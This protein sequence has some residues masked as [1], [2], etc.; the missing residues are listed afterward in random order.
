MVNARTM[1]TL[2]VRTGGTGTEFRSLAV[3]FNTYGAGDSVNAAPLDGVRVAV[4]ASSLK[5]VVQLQLPKGCAFTKD[6][7][8]AAC[9][10]GNLV[11]GHGALTLGV[12]AAVGAKAGAAGS[13]LF[14]VTATNAV[15]QTYAGEPADE[16]SDFVGVVD[17]PDIVV[18][19]LGTAIRTP[20][21][22]TTALPLRITN[23]GS[24]AAKGVVVFIHDQAGHVTIP[25]N[26]DNCVYQT[27]AGGQRGAQ[28]TFP[29]A[30]V[31][32]GQTVELSAP[33]SV[34]APAG[35][36]GDEVFYGAGLTGDS[37]IGT[38]TGAKA[39]KGAA[40][41]LVAVPSSF[42]VVR[43]THSSGV[44][45][46]TTD[47]YAYTDLNTGVITQVSAV[48]GS[49]HGKV[50]KVTT[51]WVG[52]RNSG[53][54]PIR[55]SIPMGPG[56]KGTV[57]VFVDF[58]GSVK[59]VTVPKGCRLQT[60]GPGAGASA[61]GPM[62]AYDCVSSA[63]LAPGR[64]VYFGFGIR[65]SKVIGSEFAGVYATAMTDL[66]ADFA[67]QFARLYLSAVRG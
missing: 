17:G 44:D 34:D 26:A 24:E 37:W 61:D 5:G 57:G 9:S 47:D 54:S 51:A 2:P 1:R 8:H 18:G 7:L 6:Q 16:D 58:P 52:A 3:E 4:D 63:A 29:A 64:S 39:G 32:P 25:G 50:G 12:R 35:A 31:Q 23:L 10:L 66:N 33:F 20:A 28:C 53:N 67:L 43:T 30:V 21:G 65:P 56:V 19:N 36:H 14:K 62:T 15:E 46:D 38:P 42:P 22:R 59:V 40:L 48:G 49:F 55:Q 45:I 41:K 11:S 60:A 13:V 27:Q